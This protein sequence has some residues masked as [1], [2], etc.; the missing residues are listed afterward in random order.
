MNK[1]NDKGIAIFISLILLFLI[2]LLVAAVLLTSFNYAQITEKQIKRIKAMASAEAGINYA[3]WKLGP[4]TDNTA[5]ASTYISEGTADKIYPDSSGLE[6][7]IWIL[8]GSPPYT[9]KSKVDY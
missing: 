5:Y 6:V 1:Y 8:G 4:K 9:V 2:S 3:Y 7:K